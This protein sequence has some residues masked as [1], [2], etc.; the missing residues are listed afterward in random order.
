MKR[1]NLGGPPFKCQ[2]ISPSN[3]SSPP[4]KCQG[5]G[6]PSV[7][8]GAPQ[9]SLRQDR[10]PQAYP[11]F[12]GIRKLPHTQI[13]PRRPPKRVQQVDFDVGPSS[14]N[15]APGCFAPQ[16]SRCAPQMSPVGGLPINHPQ[17]RPLVRFH[18]AL[19]KGQEDTPGA[20][21]AVETS[22]PSANTRF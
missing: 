14:I 22:V 12:L 18:K 15:T 9:V 5:Y 3:V 6:P 2:Y 8:T 7:S 16:V 21:R 4:L 17:G 19:R 20:R 11:Q 13:L 1:G 10:Y